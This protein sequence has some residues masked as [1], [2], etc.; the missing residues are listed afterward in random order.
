MPTLRPQ[1]LPEDNSLDRTEMIPVQDTVTNVTSK[2]LYEKVDHNV[3]DIR[4]PCRAFRV[5]TLPGD[6]PSGLPLATDIQGGIAYVSTSEANLQDQFFIYY[7]DGTN[8]VRLDTSAV[9]AW[10]A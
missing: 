7:S 1:D 2:M 4:R 9:S 8:W 6:R 10:G 3:T 5:G